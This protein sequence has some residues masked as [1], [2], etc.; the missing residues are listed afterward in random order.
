MLILPKLQCIDDTGGRL[1]H[2]HGMKTEL[3]FFQLIPLTTFNDPANGFL[4]NDTCMFGAEVFVYKTSSKGE[5]L[6]M[7]NDADALSYTWKIKRF[8][9]LKG[10]SHSSDVFTAGDKKWKI[11]LYPQGHGVQKKKMLSLYL[12]LDDSEVL[13]YGEKVYV[14]YKL[15]IRSPKVG[16]LQF[17]VTLPPDFFFQKIF[18]GN[19][20]FR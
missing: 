13:S 19:I 15:R 7:V 1:R 18:N 16:I 5:S 6:S 14:K 20:I 11:K 2:F 10:G 3:G 12:I 9:Q 4:I 17:F 8:S